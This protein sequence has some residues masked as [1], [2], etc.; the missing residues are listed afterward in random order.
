MNTFWEKCLESL[1]MDPRLFGGI[2][3]TWIATL[4]VEAWNPETGELVLAAAS[5]RKK[6]STREQFGSI[7]AFHASQ[8]NGGQDV[9]ITWRVKTA[10]PKPAQKPAE[11]S[12]DPAMTKEMF[13]NLAKSK[14]LVSSLSFDKF[15]QGMSNKVAVGAAMYVANNPGTKTYNPLYIYGGV[16]LGKTHLMHAIGLEMLWKN[17]QAKILCI[18]A[19]TYVSTF[20][21]A[22]A[23][24]DQRFLERFADLDLLMIDD[25]QMLGSK[26]ETQKA[27][28]STFEALVPFGKQIVLTS[29]T[30]A[31]QL[32]EV[33]ARLKSRFAGGM[34]VPIDPPEL[35][36]REA[37]LMKKAAQ[38]GVTLPENVAYFIANHLKTNV[39]ELEGALQRVIAHAKFKGLDISIEQ[40]RE[41]LQDQINIHTE[42]TVQDIQKKVADFYKIRVADMHSK[43]RPKQVA[44]P[45]QIAMYLCKKL[46]QKSYPEIGELFG[47]RDHT[48]VLHACRKIEGDRRSNDE[49][50]HELHVLEQTLQSL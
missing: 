23:K 35:E 3:D 28:F 22:S 42:I 39:R 37:I 25:V 48:T 6:D 15:V 7:I 29:D 41:A 20:I 12:S 44:V 38:N 9:R 18:P 19:S 30:Y 11:P 47:G 50:N 1:E 45:R 31:K 13:E 21:A 36:T 26:S 46:T 14:G 40:T 2:F 27:F 43:R 8:V 24:K 16:G 17:P 5:T 34:S 10:A 33:D 32:K 49:L 4:S